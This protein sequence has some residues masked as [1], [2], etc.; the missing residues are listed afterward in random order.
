MI[1]Y[2]KKTITKTVEQ[3]VEEIMTCDLC[4]FTSN[5][6]ENWL[7]NNRTRVS[8]YIETT[9]EIKEGNRWPEGGDYQSRSFHL[10][11]G[12]FL[13]KLIPW[14]ESQGAKETFKEIDW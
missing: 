8:E 1:E 11:P 13:D 3:V 5:D 12:C 10:C 9:I 7:G 4:G 14:L 2:K 6:D